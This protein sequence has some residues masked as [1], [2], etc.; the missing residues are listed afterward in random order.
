MGK[1]MGKHKPEAGAAEAAEVPW[2]QRLTVEGKDRSLRQGSVS[3]PQAWQ[4]RAR[5]TGGGSHCFLLHRCCPL[6]SPTAGQ[7]AGR[8]PRDQPPVESGRAHKTAVL[9]GASWGLSSAPA[10]QPSRAAR[11]L[12]SGLTIQP[13]LWLCAFSNLLALNSSTAYLSQLASTWFLQYKMSQMRDV[14]LN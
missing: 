7:R 5:A 2:M 3:T 13:C 8:S 6:A 12:P 1:M 9:E 10:S 11:L 4:Q 14:H